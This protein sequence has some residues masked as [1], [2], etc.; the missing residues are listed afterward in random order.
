MIHIQKQAKET[1]NIN[2][3][4]KS[5][6]FLPFYVLSFLLG[7]QA[8]SDDPLP[9]A[10]SFVDHV[11]EI[12]SFPVVTLKSGRKLVLSGVERPATGPKPMMN[13][14]TSQHWLSEK[15]LD[16]QVVIQPSGQSFD[17]LGRIHGLLKIKGQEWVN[18]QL[19][20]SG[21]A[22]AQASA[23]FTAH[24]DAMLSAEK[25][26]QKN[27]RGNWGQRQWGQGTLKVYAAHD[28]QGPE[29]GYVIVEGKIHQISKRKNYIYINFGKDWRQ[30][31][32]IGIWR[33]RNHFDSKTLKFKDWEG[34]NIQVRGLVEQW[35][36][37]FIKL[38]LPEHLILLE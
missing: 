13:L 8:L 3:L 23:G 14:S 21:Q 28:Y 36:G 25:D 29:S 19:L 15:I 18:I 34:K 7:S 32:T 12:N 37:P 17:F 10:H 2:I 6:V 1:F 31:F 26:A 24:F 35:N 20:Q 38:T 11:S 22:R 9:N 33:A 27:A 5:C 4:A 16:R 30:D